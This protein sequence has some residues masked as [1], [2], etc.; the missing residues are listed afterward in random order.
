LIG[1]EASVFASPSAH[2]PG[3][4][5][6]AR[7]RL[8]G[9]ENE[10]ASARALII[11]EKV[12]LLTITGPGGVGKTRLALAVAGDVAER[13][14]DGVIWVDL[15][16]LS[17]P[18]DVPG[19]I[20]SALG[21]AQVTGDPVQAQI[22]QFLR[23]RQ[24][25]LL[26]DNCEHLRGGIADLV[27]AL[28]ATCPAL[29]ILATSR[30]PLQIRGEFELWVA[31][32]PLPRSGEPAAE[33][34]IADNPAVQ[35]FVERARAANAA[36]LGGEDSL[37]DVAE[38]CRKVDGLPLAIELAAARV[39]V[40]PLAT[41]RDRLQHRLPLLEDGPRDAPARQ[42]TIR[43]TIGW[44]Y[45]LLTPAEQTIFRW[46]A[47]FLGGCT[48]QAV[49]SIVAATGDP[50][51]DPI[52]TLTA[53][54]DCSLLRQEP[55]H[56]GARRYRMLET[57]REYGLEQLA[58][59][60]EAKKARNAH[61]EYCLALAERAAPET[62]GGN[63]VGLLHELARD[64]GNLRDALD[65]LC[66][67][68]AK[69][70]GLRLAGACGWYWYRRGHV[71]EGRARLARAIADAGAE[72]TAA[73]GRALYWA[74]ELAI[75]AGDLEEAASSAQDALA[76]WD[77]VGDPLGRALAKHAVARVE[78]YHGRW[79]AAAALYEEELPIWRETGNP[80]AIGMVLVEMAE[81]AF[82]QGEVARAR[83]TMLEA[84]ALFREAD[85]RTWL[86]ATDFYLGL[87]AVAEGRFVEAARFYRSCLSGYAEAGDAFLQSPLAGLARVAI[88]AGRPT[89]GAQ[90]LGA[91]DAELQRTGMR[92]DQF[93]RVGRD[94]A[95]V[96][97]RA[98]LGESAFAAAYTAGREFG[99]DACFAVADDM[100]LSLE[101]AEAA[102][103]AGK[104]QT[105]A[106][107]TAREREVLVLVAEGLSDRDVAQA[108]FIT[109][110][111]VRSHLTSI[112]GKLEVGSRTAAI[113]TARRLSIV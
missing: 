93:E 32:L 50:H 36:F 45:D 48:L 51:I 21:I 16:P 83:S 87:F 88:E 6:I 103:S 67:G 64:H 22:V 28:L 69:Q 34:Q 101:A 98:A 29:Q 20:E 13:F 71:Q 112:F 63:P 94:Q 60:D 19:T 105:T 49:E 55:G 70:E 41:L 27:A 59:S 38:I 58:A 43:D 4:L 78:Q 90:L 65:W 100:V 62:L 25:L 110:G 52:R 73:L 7:T 3:I 74:A 14:A 86:A 17:D 47:V 77:I 15:A 42:H 89:T 56:T 79:D 111:T 108:L 96:R 72:P 99:R 107:L 75:R 109:Q 30:A 81:V 91:A 31:P 76:V 23:S 54:L 102:H 57:I 26:L 97:A 2:L 33:Q 61:A 113:A 80:R 37:D 85:E 66:A 1:G 46:L 92:F 68:S 82:G 18:V 106:G 10:R 53:L 95:E 9:R 84:A 35:L 39:R 5:P 24:M 11:E 44:S 40:L 12:P 104:G 8:I